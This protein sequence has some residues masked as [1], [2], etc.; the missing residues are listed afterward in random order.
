MIKYLGSK[1][2]LMPVLETLFRTTQART[3]LDLFTGTTRVAQ[4]LKQQSMHVT[5][6]DTASYSEVFAK[7]WIELDASTVNLVELEEAVTRLNNLRGSAGY[8]TKAFCEQARY[9]Q[10]KNGERIDSIRA[11]IESDYRQS[12]LY[13]PLL[14][15]LLVAADKIDSTTGVQMAYLKSWSR[16]SSADLELKVPELMPGSGKSLRAD[17]NSAIESLPAVEL[18]YLDPPY[19]QH[20]YFGNY[21]IWETLV[22]WDSPE[23][24]GIANKRLDTRDA[25]NK[26]QF[27]SKLTMPAALG[28]LITNLKTETLVLSYNNESWLSRRELTDMCAKFG[29]VEILDFDFKRYVGSQIGGY[30]QSGELVGKPGAKRNL[31]HIVLAGSSRIVAELVDS[32]R[33]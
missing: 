5:A 3:A 14:A 4:A 10:P 19:N 22:R 29:A 27:N 20:R 16:R 8:F 7:T 30:N 6:V 32:V 2:S 26:S 12:W 25:E 13:F 15:S 23:T 28:Q 31:E 17:A 1:R 33:R 21:H 11:V 9:F 24:Y 18:A